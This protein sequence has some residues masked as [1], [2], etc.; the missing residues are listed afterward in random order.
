VEPAWQQEA[1]VLTNP[2]AA[3]DS[4]PLELAH[5]LRHCAATILLLA[6][7]LNTE[8]GD[9][10]SARSALDGINNCARTIAAL[11]NE[12][13]GANSI[14][15]DVVAEYVVAQARLIHDGPVSL[16]TSPV[17]AAASQID[18]VR[19]IAN[20]VDNARA[21][22]G[23][24]GALAIEI[25]ATD[26]H[27][28]IQ[29]GDSGCGFPDIDLQ[30]SGLGLSIV[31]RLTTEM[32]GSITLSRSSLGGALVVVALPRKQRDTTPTH[33]REGRNLCGS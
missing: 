31:L 2:D 8:L 33:H 27:V 30:P 12:R 15:V 5:D 32:G 20:L 28:V 24:D 26:T 6:T 3:Q 1:L 7:T 23:N 4:M 29:V 22:A 14:R 9:R 13:G 19:I 16:V 11:C 25:S 21:A 17:D 10:V 18:V